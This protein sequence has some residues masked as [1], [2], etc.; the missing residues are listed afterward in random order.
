[1]DI[2][3]ISSN[4]VETKTVLDRTSLSAVWMKLSYV[5]L[6]RGIVSHGESYLD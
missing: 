3:S 1:M 4:V 5:M 2:V 6:R